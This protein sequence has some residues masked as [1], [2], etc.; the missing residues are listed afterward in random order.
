[1][2]Y[3]MVGGYVQYLYNSL[4]K[5]PNLQEIVSRLGV[6]NFLKLL[7]ETNSDISEAIYQGSWVLLHIHFLRPYF[8]YT[9]C[10]S[11]SNLR[12]KQTLQEVI[13]LL[14]E[15]KFWGQLKC[16][17]KFFNLTWGLKKIQRIKIYLFPSFTCSKYKS[18]GHTGMLIMK[19]NEA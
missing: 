17:A 4:S 14:H 16:G 9:H 10:K 19:T 8:T 1:M 7:I 2:L 15:H 11:F 18:T 5:T 6:S 3:I 13:S 12:T